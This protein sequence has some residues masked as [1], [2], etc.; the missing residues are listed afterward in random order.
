MA[1]EQNPKN[2]IQSLA[3]GFRVLEVFSPQTPQLTL[4]EIAQRAGLDSG[5]VFRII[6]TLLSLGY[7]DRVPD[8]RRF[9]LTLKVLDLGFSAISRMELRAVAR[10]ILRSLVGQVN[11]AASLATLE[12]GEILYVERVFAGLAR[13]GVD[14]RVGT[15]LPAYYT[16]LG[17]AMLAYLPHDEM[18]RA[19]D[20]IDRVKLTPETP[21]TIQ[22][23][24]AC[25]EKVRRDGYAVSDQGVIP[26]LRILAAPIFDIDGNVFAA[27]S[28]AAPALRMP[29]DE[30]MELA[31]EPLKKVAIDIGKAMQAAGGVTVGSVATA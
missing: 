31:V 15:R 3:K 19:L 8:T 20:T 26:G 11:E 28:V 30:F 18:L 13:L 5:T 1:K 14:T 22:E 9:R 4:S 29:F 24:E 6:N 17:H 7:L 27:V 21:T 12:G 25:L 16:M 2:L 23:I 10:P